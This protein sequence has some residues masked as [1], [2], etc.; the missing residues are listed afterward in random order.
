MG[1]QLIEHHWNTGWQLLRTP[2]LP[3]LLQVALLS[4]LLAT[5]TLHGQSD[6]LRRSLEG[7]LSAECPA[8][9][10]YSNRRPDPV[11][12]A[13]P[14]RVAVLYNDI[15]DI[16]DSDQTFTVDAWVAARWRDP[17]LADASRGSAQ[18]LCEVEDGQLWLP[19][20]AI[21]NI[22]KYELLREVMLIDAEG[23]VS[24]FRQAIITVF[25]HFDLRDFPFD[26]QNLTLK[27][28]SLYGTSDVEFQELEELSFKRQ[29]SVPGWRL[30][31]P[32]TAIETEQALLIKRSLLSAEIEA[33]REPGVFR[34][35]LII[36]VALIVFMAYA[37][38][39]ISP[40][41]IPPQ[42]GIGTTSML[43][44]I[45]Y[46]FALGNSLPQISYLTRADFF[47]LCSLA[48]VFTA[49]A[50]AIVTAALMNYEK[51]S[52]ARKMDVLFR[53]LYPSAFAVVVI[54]TVA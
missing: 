33:E 22:R 53:V 17:R 52:A 44:L 31:E 29:A 5:Q 13:T 43:T 2:G 40:K 48:L 19:E 28:E 32:R 45:A 23:T 16:S 41:L 36:P 46:Q 25:S 1:C 9:E 27:F 54:A 51:E 24:H 38:F 21:R 3:T 8:P 50:E 7:G 30:S 11:G 14:V 26:R 12:T 4:S 39:W 15:L 20:I 47:L 35:K 10:E 37:I 34:R 18:A 49:L 42:T 6:E